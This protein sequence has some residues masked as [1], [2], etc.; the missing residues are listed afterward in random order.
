MS[1]VSINSCDIVEISINAVSTLH[2]SLWLDGTSQIWF[3]QFKC[4]GYKGESHGLA[5]TSH[6][7]VNEEGCVIQIRVD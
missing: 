3:E 2:Q 1:S 4:A 5:H 6:L 7:D